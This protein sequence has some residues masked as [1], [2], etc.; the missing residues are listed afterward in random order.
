M[1]PAQTGFT[2]E[3]GLPELEGETAALIETELAVFAQ[4]A[5][6]AAGGEQIGHAAAGRIVAVVRPLPR[7]ARLAP[8]VAVEGRGVDLGAGIEAGIHQPGIFRAEAG[9][10]AVEGVVFE[11]VL[12][13]VGLELGECQAGI[14]DGRVLAVKARL[15]APGA[16]FVEL[17]EN[18]GGDVFDGGVHVVASAVAFLVQQV[19]PEGKKFELVAEGHLATAI[20]AIAT[21]EPEGQQP[22]VRGIGRQV[23]DDAAGGGRSKSDLAGTFDH[24]DAG[25]TFDR[26]MVIGGVVAIRRKGQKNAVFQHQDLGAAGGV[27]AAQADIGPQRET[28]LVAGKKAGNLAQGFVELR[29]LG[30]LQV[31]E[32]DPVVRAGQT[33]EFVRV[34]Y[35]PFTDHLDLVFDGRGNRGRRRGS[36]GRRGAEGGF[37]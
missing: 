27:D 9:P 19:E 2:F 33:C 20:G 5:L 35:Q 12:P 4:P 6:V 36:L 21:V 30:T 23:V 22:I 34:S 16:A 37:G 26:R 17:V 28:F 29:D 1:V 8:P 14:G 31:E 15:G 10:F 25:E 24:L 11:G 13:R 32:I 3:E 7:V 18:F